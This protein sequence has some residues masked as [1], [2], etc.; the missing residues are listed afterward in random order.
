[1][2]RKSLRKFNLY[3]NSRPTNQ[4]EPTVVLGKMGIRDRNTGKYRTQLF[5]DGVV[6]SRFIGRSAS[7]SQGTTTEIDKGG[8]SDN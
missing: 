5:N 1:M 2:D 6:M 7:K 3:L 8:W 4:M